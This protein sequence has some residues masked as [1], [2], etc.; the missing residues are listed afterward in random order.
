MFGNWGRAII[1]MDA[2][3]EPE[4][5]DVP[6]F[7]RNVLVENNEFRLVDSRIVSAVSVDGFVFRNNKIIR[8]DDYP[9]SSRQVEPFIMERSVHVDIE[10]E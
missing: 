3:K 2:G 1:S 6:R 4:P 5:A 9:F 7:N 10:K 8:S